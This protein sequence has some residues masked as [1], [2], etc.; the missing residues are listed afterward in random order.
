MNCWLGFYFPAGHCVSQH[1]NRLTNAS[2]AAFVPVIGFGISPTSTLEVEILLTTLCG[3]LS[4]VG[5]AFYAGTGGSTLPRVSH[6]EASTSLP[7][8]D[9]TASL[10]GAKSNAASITRESE[11]I[12]MANK[13]S[14]VAQMLGAE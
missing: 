9:V 2:I 3:V 11:R 13:F 8:N 10:A 4:L 5:Y 12:A 14:K 6:N 1:S 7:N